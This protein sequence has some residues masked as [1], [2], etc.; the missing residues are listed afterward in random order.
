MD[1]AFLALTFGFVLFVAR[2]LYG[3][4]FSPLGIYAIVWTGTMSLAA[5]RFIDYNALSDTTIAAVSFSGIAM[6][7][8]S[9]IGRARLRKYKPTSTAGESMPSVGV[10]STTVIILFAL[11]A[12]GSVIRITSIVRQ[13]GSVITLLQNAQTVRAYISLGLLDYDPVSA[14]L[15]SLAFAGIP[16]AVL[17]W[18]NGGRRL[19]L[20]LPFLPL[21]VNDI[22]LNSRT[23]IVAGLLTYLAAYGIVRVLVKQRGLTVSDVRRLAIIGILFAALSAVVQMQRY[24]DAPE[25]YWTF[26]QH[27][28]GP[29]SGISESWSGGMALGYVYFTSGIPAFNELVQSISPDDY[30]GGLSTFAPF[31]RATA[32]FLAKVECPD[33]ISSMVYMPVQSNIYSFLQTFYEDFGIWGVIIYPLLLGFV[34]ANAYASIRNGWSI[35]KYIILVF[36]FVIVF[37]STYFNVISITPVAIGIFAATGIAAV[38]KILPKE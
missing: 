35:V 6:L 14:Y 19:F 1:F 13:F 2:R 8:G 11:S 28:R 34:A 33:V 32:R 24:G 22:A 12:A 38:M 37:G 30:W 4:F 23:W 3:T 21:L 27:W 5:L 25:A 36:C 10:L 9:L 17:L 15:A 18:S 26:G 29:A 16:F 7:V 31:C 20:I